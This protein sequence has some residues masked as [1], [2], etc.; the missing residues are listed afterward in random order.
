MKS[1]QLQRDIQG[2]YLH[3]VL[4]IKNWSPFVTASLLSLF[5]I[6]S[7]FYR[8]TL[9]CVRYSSWS[10]GLR[11]PSGTPSVWGVLAGV[12][13]TCVW[14]ASLPCRLGW[15]AGWQPLHK[16]CRHWRDTGSAQCSPAEHCLKQVC[17]VKSHWYLWP[18]PTD[19]PNRFVLIPRLGPCQ[20]WRQMAR[21]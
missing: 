3:L 6:E 16:G 17:L 1:P 18:V 20:W 13:G 15:G 4:A 21:C 10:G 12:R 2:L 11:E 14:L 8:K 5:T 9:F 19:V 7:V